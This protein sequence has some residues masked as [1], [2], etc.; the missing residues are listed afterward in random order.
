MYRQTANTLPYI[1]TMLTTPFPTFNYHPHQVDA[2]HWMLRREHTDA[3]YV[4]GGILADEMGL[5]KT[6]MTIGLL[7]NAPVS[8]TLLLVPPVLSNQW[9]TAL[10]QSGI[11]HRILGPPSKKGADGSWAKVP[12]TQPVAV[13]LSTYD[14]AYRNESLIKSTSYER[15][16]CDEGHVLRN[17]NSIKRFRIISGFTAARRWILSGTPIQNNKN[18]FQ[19][20]LSFLHMDDDERIRSTASVVAQTVILRRTVGMVREAVPT[21]P[22]VPPTHTVHPVVMPEGSEEARVFAALV[23]RFEHAVE[24]HAKAMIILELYL[25]IQQFVADP[26]IYVEAMKRKF[27]TLYTR[28]AWTG[29]TSKMTTFR[30]VITTVTKKP[31][32]VFGTFRQELDLAAMALREAGYTV[33]MIRGGMTQASRDSAATDS[34]RDVTA[35]RD[36]AIVIQINAGGAG[37]NLQ[38]CERVMFLSSHWNPAVM[39]QAVARAYRMGQKAD[40]EV[41]H[42][43]LADDVERNIDRRMNM[44]HGHKR[45]VAVGIHKDLY[46]DA[47]ANT[48]TVVDTLNAVLPNVVETA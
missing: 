23:G 14:R 9:S 10:Q 20:L 29:T 33:Y 36:V 34:A 27:K 13:T 5:G 15:I 40:V 25:R 24:T 42:F 44:L 22:S 1:L 47:A 28:E 26:S 17:G 37:L 2:I 43:L 18:D 12:G 6:W 31:T 19:H 41:H 7:L 8:E 32:I 16:I 21:M 35:G 45:G 11:P 3:D 4:R 46:C 39:D 38:H 30:K 48:E